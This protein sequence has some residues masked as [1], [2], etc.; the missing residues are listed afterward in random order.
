LPSRV[1]ETQL[2]SSARMSRLKVLGG[3]A[4]AGDVVPAGSG[5]LARGAFAGGAGAEPVESGWAG[6]VR[7]A[8]KAGGDADDGGGVMGALLVGDAVDAD[9]IVPG[10]SFPGDFV[11]EAFATVRVGA[12]ADEAGAVTRAGD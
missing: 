7:S 5:G 3:F 8:F 4:A 1:I 12:G 2:V 6:A 11:L 9:E 10:E